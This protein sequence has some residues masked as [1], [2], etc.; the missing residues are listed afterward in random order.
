VS[1]EEQSI[2][3][4]Q[5]LLL[6]GKPGCGKTTVIRRAVEG[7]SDAGGFYTDEVRDGDRRTGFSIT[8]LDGRS[9]MLAGTDISSGIRLG[10]YGVNVPDIDEI[11]ASSIESAVATDSVNT[12]V[13]DEIASMEMASDRFRKAVLTAI[14]GNKKV[15]GTIQ[16]RSHPFL[17]G[18]RTHPGVSLVEVRHHNRETLPG[19]I[20]EWLDR[21]AVKH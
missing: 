3:D 21:T 2:P 19:L 1:S 9:G 14:F 17:D 20:G 4:T 15:L 12:V 8:T 13:I 10:R 5:N 16:A 11:A 18:I 6:T 7:R